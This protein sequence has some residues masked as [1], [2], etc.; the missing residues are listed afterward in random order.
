[1]MVIMMM[2]T[3]VQEIVKLNLDSLA[4]EVLL[5]SKIIVYHKDQTKPKLNWL[6]KLEDRRVL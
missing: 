3:V 2:E 1:M 6:D 5:N 4:Q